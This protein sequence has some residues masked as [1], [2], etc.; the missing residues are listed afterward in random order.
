MQLRLRERRLLTDSIDW[1]RDYSG[2]PTQPGVNHWTREWT[3]RTGESSSPSHRLTAAAL[4]ENGGERLSSASDS[5]GAYLIQL[6]CK[7][8][9]Q[10]TCVNYKEKRKES[11]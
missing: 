6:A 10:E 2:D 4:L 5:T 8:K 7:S 3:V 11:D 9:D 1:L